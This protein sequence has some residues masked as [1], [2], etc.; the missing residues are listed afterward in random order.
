M[1]V[2]TIGD[3][4]VAL[5]LSGGIVS[6]LFIKHATRKQRMEIIH[7]ERMAALEKGIPLPEFPLDLME[8]KPHAP[9][10]PVLPVLGIILST[11]SIGTMVVLYLTMP[12]TSH[13]W[14]IS[15]LPFVFM[16]AGLILFHVLG[17]VRR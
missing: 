13:A 7:Q 11:L 1:S 4:L 9:D 17:M 15:P 14:W 3:G 5:A 8:E 12:P 10:V 6:Y 16:G 2:T